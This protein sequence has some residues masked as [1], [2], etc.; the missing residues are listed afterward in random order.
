LS[1]SVVSDNATRRTKQPKVKKASH[2]KHGEEPKPIIRIFDQTPD[3]VRTEMK[4]EPGDEA[5]LESL[6]STIRDMKEEKGAE[7]IDEEELQD[8]VIGRHMQ[9]L[10]QGEALENFL[11]AKLESQ[12][13]ELDAE[14]D[15]RLENVD[16]ENMSEE[17]RSKVRE[18]L[19]HLVK[20]S[21]DPP[22]LLYYD[23]Y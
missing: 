21:M 16:L 1:R 18:E 22:V 2:D 8:R 23:I 4:N 3:G 20:E 7:E 13:D 14:I 17:E 15:K 19:Y 5:F 11:A 10:F 6:E 12:M 9:K